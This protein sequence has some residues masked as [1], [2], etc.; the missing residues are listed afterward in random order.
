L[1]RKTALVKGDRVATRRK[2]L[3]EGDGI[4]M[5]KKGTRSVGIVNG[6]CYFQP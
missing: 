3:V 4:A 1:H 2:A 5:R 6:T